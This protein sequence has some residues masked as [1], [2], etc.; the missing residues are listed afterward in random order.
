MSKVARKP[1]IIP[2]DVT[3]S[4]DKQL[5]TL[6]KGS[7]KLAREVHPSVE[8]VFNENELTFKAIAGQENS[9]AQSG[10]ERSLVNNNLVGITDGFKIELQ[11]VGVGY[12][13]KLEGKKLV[14]SLG[15]SHQI[16]YDIPEGITIDLPTQTEVNVSGI[17]KHLVGQAAAHI[18]AYRKPD[19]Y[20]GKGVRYK[21]V[22]IVLKEG[23]K[24]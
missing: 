16:I 13:A 4:I 3:C 21:N 20:K 10:T 17:D 7:K 24:K 6:Q 11:I 5:I 23:K 2:S 8:I 18:A 15:Y 12:R 14:L 22:P 1:I 9:K 19:A